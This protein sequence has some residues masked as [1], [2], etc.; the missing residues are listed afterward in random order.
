MKPK[1]QPTPSNT[2]PVQKWATRNAGDP[3]DRAQHQH[4]EPDRHNPLDAEPDDQ[5][6]G[7]KARHEHAEHV[8]L[9]PERRFADRMIA[10]H[11]GERRR[12]HHHV[13]HRI[14]GDAAGDRD[15]EAR[16]TRDLGQRAS[17]ARR[18][19]CAAAPEFSGASGRPRRPRRAPACA[20]KVAANR[21]GGSTSLVKITTCGPTMPETMPPIITHEIALGLNASLA[22]SAA[23]KR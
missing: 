23:A 1:F 21:Y 14:A 11:H 16:L 17:F 15:D 13:H 20:R 8:P 4:A 3:D 12:G 2:S 22:V 6:A 10:H 19:A 9:Q 18:P 5:V 7:E